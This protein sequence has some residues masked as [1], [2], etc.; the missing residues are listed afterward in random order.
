MI[1]KYVT[2]SIKGKLFTCFIDFKKALIFN[3]GVNFMTS[4]KI[5]TQSLSVLSNLAIKKTEYFEYANG[6]RHGC[7]ISLM[8]FNPI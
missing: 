1:D 6:A 3:L 2:H 8:L 7:I 5:F 4:L